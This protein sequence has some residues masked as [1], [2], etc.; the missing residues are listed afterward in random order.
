MKSRR[1]LTLLELLLA[2]LLFGLV[3]AAVVS[4]M[5]TVFLSTANALAKL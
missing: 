3:S 1:G 2:V 5:S 4:V